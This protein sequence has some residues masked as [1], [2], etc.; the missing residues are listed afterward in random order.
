M[1]TI[2]ALHH[3]LDIFYKSNFEKWSMSNPLYAISP[4]KKTLTWYNYQT[5]Q[6]FYSYEEYYAWVADNLQYSIALGEN[7]L[8]QIFYQELENGVSKGSLSFLPHPDLLMT[9]MRFDMDKNN[10]KHYYHNSFHI[11][12]GYR[13]EE[14]RFSLNRFPHPSEFIRFCLFLMG[15]D[16]FENF[17][18]NR[19]FNDLT[20]FGERH[21]HIFDFTLT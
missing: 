7:I 12:F 13:S 18:R 17:N 9:Y 21:S 11:H 20:T 19:F 10:W 8:L 2:R 5:K 3:N 1:S 16:E 14:L 4:D 6:S 15:N